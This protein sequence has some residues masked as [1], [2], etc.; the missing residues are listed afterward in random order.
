MGILNF[1]KKKKNKIVF[2]NIKKYNHLVNQ[3]LQIKKT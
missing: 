3:V 1:G 2:S